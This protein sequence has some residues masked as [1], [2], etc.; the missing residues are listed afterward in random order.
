MNAEPP[1]AADGSDASS[2][3]AAAHNTLSRKS[4][5]DSGNRAT[6][7]VHTAAM[8]FSYTVETELQIDL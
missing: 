3:P 5:C 4:I 1:C 2:A 7:G 8:A 6:A